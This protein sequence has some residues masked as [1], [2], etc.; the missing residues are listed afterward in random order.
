MGSGFFTCAGI[1]V[2]TEGTEHE[3]FTDMGCFMSCIRD[4]GVDVY[5]SNREGQ[6]DKEG[7]N[8]S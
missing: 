5:T 4:H 3:E 8:N 6:G 1:R 2:E 7:C